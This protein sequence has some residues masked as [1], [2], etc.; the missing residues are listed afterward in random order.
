MGLKRML[1]NWSDFRKQDYYEDEPYMWGMSIDLNK[2][3]GCGACVTAC[4]AEN[5]LPTVGKEHYASGHSMHWMRIERYWEEP[6]A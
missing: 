3:I 5:N 6:E 4:Y 2:C 1:E